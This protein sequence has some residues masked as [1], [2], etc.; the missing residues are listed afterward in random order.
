MGTTDSSP[1]TSGASGQLFGDTLRQLRLTSELAE[2]SNLSVRG[3]SDLERGINRSPRRE[4][5]LAL[6]NVFGLDGEERRHFVAA[7][8]RRPSLSAS[9]GS[10]TSSTSPEPDPPMNLAPAGPAGQSSDIKVFLIADVRGYSTYT[11]E[12]RDEDAAELTLRFAALADATVQAH[13]GQV[14]EV[15]GDEVLAVFSSARAALRAAISLQEQVGQASAT[16]PEQ[17]IHCGV[18]VEAG[19]AVAVPGGYRGQAIN[20]AARLCS[21]AGP[22]DVLAGEVAIRLARKVAGLVFQDRGLATL[23]GIAEPV[24]ITQVLAVE[25][26]RAEGTTQA[27]LVYPNGAPGYVEE[28]ALEAGTPSQRRLAAPGEFCGSCPH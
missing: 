21:Q 9:I 27:M 4:T 3:L 6:A 11:Y 12:H 18:G 26:G 13:S 8:R 19:E 23:N 2:R 24:Q 7:A 22:G 28:S 14:L 10:L 1:N 17:P 16:T 15:R 25:A 5:L 20:L